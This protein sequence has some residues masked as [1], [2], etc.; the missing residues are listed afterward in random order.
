MTPLTEI[1]AIVV[2]SL[3]GVLLA[4]RLGLPSVIGVLIF[5]ALI[6]PHGLNIVPE[7]NIIDV[8][9][10]MGA[11]FL[12]FF[13]GLE[14]SIEKLV[15]RG[16][17]ALSLFFF[18]TGMTFLLC[19]ITSLL[20]GL[21]IFDSILVAILFSFSS[22]AIFARFVQDS[23]A[24]NKKEAQILTAVLIME[25][26]AAVFLL[27]V[28]AQLKNIGAVSISAVILP[29]II[30]LVVFSFSYLILRTIVKIFIDKFVIENNAEALLFTALS[31]CALFASLGS[32][33]GLPLSIGAFLAGNIFSSIAILKKSKNMLTNFIIVFSSF[34][35]FSIG[36]LMNPLA[37]LSIW[38]LLAVFFIVVLL[39]KFL[40]V[41]LPSYLFGFDSRGAVFS[42]IMML[43]IS[44]FALIIAKEANPLTSLD[45]ITL[46]GSLLFFT[47]LI[48]GILYK[49]E[50]FVDRALTALLPKEIKDKLRSFSLYLQNVF[51]SFEPGGFFY[52]T[53]YNEFKVITFNATLLVMINALLLLII[54]FID[55]LLNFFGLRAGVDGNIVLVFVGVSFVLSAYPLFLVMRAIKNLF[56]GFPRAFHLAQHTYLNIENRIAFDL[57]MFFLFFCSAFLILILFAALSL[58]ALFN[59]VAILPLI[60]SFSFALDLGGALLSHATHRKE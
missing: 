42:G 7:T 33:F 28:F 54:H 36:M 27:A 6:G 49:K 10:E 47:A 53:A 14:F 40:S 55:A 18:K 52:T 9:S 3:L 11:V 19:Y 12:L 8:F 23:G 17:R 37:I 51:E 29:T 20:L 56:L 50:H 46:S 30:S 45:V 59:L 43:T 58:P 34:F 26:L 35:F 13:I 22:T 1:W 2:F 21:S 24:K 32:L 25:D 48:S 4:N 60:I 16:L 5:G 44:E 31:L 15:K 57:F 39:A 38:P 41:S